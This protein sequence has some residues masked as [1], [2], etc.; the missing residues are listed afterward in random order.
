MNPRGNI[1]HTIHY[2]FLLGHG[3]SPQRPWR[4]GK[5]KHLLLSSYGWCAWVFF[6]FGAEGW[7]QTWWAC[8]LK[9]LWLAPYC[10]FLHRR[11][12]SAVILMLN[13]SEND[14]D[15][16]ASMLIWQQRAQTILSSTEKTVMERVWD[17]SACRESTGWMLLF[18]KELTKI[19]EQ[20]K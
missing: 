20:R 12:L 13:W 3:D 16:M 17:N 9:D 10:Q 6:W 15:H 4:L 19:G 8:R 18:W 14:L 1:L 5:S 7:K 2:I 11:R